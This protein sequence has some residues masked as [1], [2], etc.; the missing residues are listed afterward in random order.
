MASSTIVTKK[1]HKFMFKLNGYS[2]K[3]TELSLLLAAQLF[4]I[5][6]KMFFL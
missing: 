6:G 2:H 5:F 3:K 1:K 4:T